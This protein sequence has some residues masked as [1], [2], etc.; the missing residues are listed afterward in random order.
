MKT[1]A[2]RRGRQRRQPVGEV[3]KRV[4]QHAGREEPGRPIA[5]NPPPL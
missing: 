4:D 5:G 2:L 3:A 1:I